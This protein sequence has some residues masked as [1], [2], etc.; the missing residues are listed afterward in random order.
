MRFWLQISVNQ[1]LPVSEYPIGVILSYMKICG[2]IDKFMFFYLADSL[3][4]LASSL[5]LVPLPADTPVSIVTGVPA[6]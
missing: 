5:L 3:L 4:P 2:D 6:C 1:F